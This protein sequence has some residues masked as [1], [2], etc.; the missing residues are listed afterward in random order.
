MMLLVASFCQTVSAQAF[1]RGTRLLSVGIGGTNSFLFDPYKGSS[2]YGYGYY[3]SFYSRLS[4]VVNVQMEFAVHQY[5][6]VGFTAGIGGNNGVTGY[7]YFGAYDYAYGDPQI[8]VP[9]GAFAN[10]HFYQIIADKTGKGDRMHADKLDVYAGLNIGSGFAVDFDRYNKYG[11]TR[12]LPMFFIGP[13]VGVR[14]FFKPNIGVMGEI[15]YGKTFVNAGITFKMGGGSSRT[16]T[17]SKPRV[18]AKET[19]K[20]GLGKDTNSGN[21]SN[22]GSNTKTVPANNGS[23]KV[24]VTPAKKK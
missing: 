6:G 12:I 24:V 23:S 1:D 22:T 3:R 7:G 19:P 18:E 14:Y 17:Q 16:E 4:G 2:Y 10:C 8:V 11:G 15:G 13:Q 5:V 9:V 21:K 20:A